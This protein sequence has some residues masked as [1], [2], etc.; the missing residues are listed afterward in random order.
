MNKSLPQAT[1]VLSSGSTPH[2]GLVTH[3]ATPSTELRHHCIRACLSIIPPLH[4]FVCQYGRIDATRAGC[5]KRRQLSSVKKK[6][7]PATKKK[8]SQSKTNR[9]RNSRRREPERKEDA[10]IDSSFV[11]NAER[12]CWQAACRAAAA[13]TCHLILSR[14]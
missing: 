8:R 10:F 12:S 9:L 7:S 6:M 3:N 13:L 14:R 2:T 5:T 1:C 4:T 11:R